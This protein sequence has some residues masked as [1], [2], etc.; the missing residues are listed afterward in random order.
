[1]MFQNE[2]IPKAHGRRFKTYPGGGTDPFLTA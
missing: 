1:M 2:R